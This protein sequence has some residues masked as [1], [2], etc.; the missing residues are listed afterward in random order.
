ME[1]KY[2]EGAIVFEKIRPQQKLFVSRC[3]SGLYYCRVE[4]DKT[5]KELVYFERDILPF[6]EHN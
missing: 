5:R 1:A 3:Q 4:E 2:K 6:R